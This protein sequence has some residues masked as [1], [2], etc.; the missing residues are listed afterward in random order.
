M[1]DA[2][3]YDEVKCKITITSIKA[4]YCEFRD[5]RNFWIPQSI[6]KNI[7]SIQKYFYHEEQILL[8]P[9]WFIKKHDISYSGWV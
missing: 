7:D 8:I 6:I 3:I 5:G 2:W 4:F 1:N 9:Q